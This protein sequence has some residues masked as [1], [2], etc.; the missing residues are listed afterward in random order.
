MYEAIASSRYLNNRDSYGVERVLDR[1]GRFTANFNGQPDRYLKKEIRV[2]KV[3]FRKLCNVLRGAEVFQSKGTKPQASVEIQLY[4]A[5]WRFGHNGNGAKVNAS[6]KDC[7]ISGESRLSLHGRWA[8]PL[9]GSVLKYTWRTIE[10]LITILGQEYLGWP[11]AQQ[12]RLSVR[13][14]AENG[15]PGGCIGIGDGVMAVFR[16]KP[17]RDDSQDYWAWKNSYGYNIFIIA[18]EEK[19]IIFLAT[20]H[21]GIANDVRVYRE[22]DIGR[23]PGTYY[24]ARQYIIVD[25]GYHSNLNVVS[26]Y[27]A[28]ELVQ[29]IDGSKVSFS[30]ACTHE[31]QEQQLTSGLSSTKWSQGSE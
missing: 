9:E 18:N 3:E 28:S 12:R 30:L 27:K 26:L 2:F 15:V 11:T 6:V 19:R 31:V 5:L 29:D 23:Y 13:E 4:C 17:A 24:D 16:G 20:G 10:A 1:E 21:P 8:D 25:G 22:S 7:G 14:F